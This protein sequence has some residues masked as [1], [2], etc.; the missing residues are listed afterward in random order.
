MHPQ[1]PAEALADRQL[2]GLQWTPEV[3][4]AFCGVRQDLLRLRE[5]AAGQAGGQAGALGL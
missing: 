3:E 4:Y 1:R 2:P 5:T